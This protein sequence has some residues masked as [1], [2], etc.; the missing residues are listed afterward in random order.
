M[1]KIILSAFILTFGMFPQTTHAMFTARFAKRI[2]L[3]SLGSAW[4]SRNYISDFKDQ[5]EY[6]IAQNLDILPKSWLQKL[7]DHVQHPE[8]SC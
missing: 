7:S 5:L 2:A 1:K 3:L 4:L 8:K 6:K